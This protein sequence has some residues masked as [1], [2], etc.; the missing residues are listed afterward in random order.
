[1]S[2]VRKTIAPSPLRFRFHWRARANQIPIPIRIIHPP[3]RRPELV[4]MQRLHRPSR[5]LPRVLVRPLIRRHRR[6]RVRRC[7]QRI[8]RLIQPA[9]FNRPD[10]LANAESSHR[11]TDPARLS[12]RS[13]SARS[14]ACPA[15]A[16]TSSGRGSRNP[17]AAWR[18]LRP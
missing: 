6:R 11:K 3:H 4:L 7:L 17:S 8:I 14:S 1:M 9:L 5:L 2:V 13:R 10:L 18:C 15:P 16:R 12:T